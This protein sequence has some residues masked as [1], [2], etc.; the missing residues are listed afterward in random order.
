MS[1]AAARGAAW[2][3]LP[4]AEWEQ[5]H[6]ALHRWLQLVG[7]L[8]LAT[9]PWIN[10]SWHVTFA[11]TARG[12]TTGP[13]PCAGRF[14]EAEFDFV[15]DRL[16]LATNDGASASV[17]LEAQSLALFH[18]RVREALASLDAPMAIR[19]LPCEIADAVPFEQDTAAR[20]YDA[21][22]V[23]RYWNALL[24]A[25]RVL[26]IFRAR[27]TGKASPVHFF[28]GAPDLAVTRFS[29]RRAPAHPGG[30]PHLADWVVR[31]AYSHE[32]SSCGFW[33][34]NGLGYP[35]FYAYAYPQPEGFAKWKVQPAAA[36]Y[37]RDLREFILPYDAVREAEDPDA[38]LL[39]F[40]QS[41]YEAAAE[42][43]R[44]D[45]PALEC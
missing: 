44:W 17:P 2:P 3:P 38:T 43:G 21:D 23:R 18:A 25:E 7:K 11:L 28:W 14:Y 41:T 4:W 15:A 16:R 12:L 10:H 13:L 32:V 31:E 1:L 39:G 37:S 19:T 35:A 24:Q 30:V 5:T 45:R 20:P 40:L 27:F 42:L 8:K 34:G 22:A 29:G 6:A 33:A 36:F 9:L 26:R